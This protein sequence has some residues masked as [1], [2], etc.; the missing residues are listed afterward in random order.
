MVSPHFQGGPFDDRTTRTGGTGTT[1]PSGNFGQ[2]FPNPFSQFM[3][4]EPKLAYYG[5]GGME[6]GGT[7]PYGSSPQARR[8]FQ[9]QFQNIYNEFLGQQGQALMGQ[10]MPDQT[11]SQFLGQYPFTERYS[12]LPPAMSGMQQRTFAPQASYRYL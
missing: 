12:A 4:Q 1:V 2:G 3:I 6:P 10:K 8:R 5:M 7:S 11:F 9:S